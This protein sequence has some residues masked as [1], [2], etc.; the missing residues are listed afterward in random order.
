HPDL[1][2]P[3]GLYLYDFAHFDALHLLIM[4]LIGYAAPDWAAVLNSYYLLG[5]ALTTVTS[6]LFFR[7]LR[8]N[9]AAAVALA[10]LFNFQ[11]Y[12]HIR[13]QGHIMLSAYYLL[14]VQMF[15]AVWLLTPLG[16]RDGE[17]VSLWRSWRLRAACVI[18]FVAVFAGH[19]Y[20]AFALITYAAAAAY[21][22]LRLGTWRPAG[23]AA[24]LWAVAAAGFAV[25]LSP[26]AAY[27]ARE[28]ANREASAKTP[29]QAE[30]YAL[31]LAP[32]LLPV[33]NHRI[34]PLRR[35]TWFYHAATPIPPNGLQ[36]VGLVA[37]AGLVG[38]LAWGVFGGRRDGL[39][40]GLGAVA[41]ALVLFSTTTGFNALFAYAVSPQLHATGRVSILLALLGLT[42]VGLVVTAAV[43]RLGRPAAGAALVAGAGLL[44]LLD[45]WP[46]V[47][48][49]DRKEMATQ[50][51]PAERFAH[52]IQRAVPEGTVIHQMPAR[53]FPFSGYEQ[54]QPYLFTKGLRW[55]CPA[56]LN[57]RGMRWSEEL[58]R[59]P[60]EEMLERLA[61]CG[62]GGIILE[63]EAAHPTTTDMRR[64]L[65]R[66]RVPRVEGET[67]KAFYDLRA[68]AE[69]I[70]GRYGVEE[71]ARRR[72]AASTPLVTLWG[73][74]FRAE[75]RPADGS[76]PFRWSLRQA[77]RIELVNHDDRP[78]RVRFRMGLHMAWPTGKGFT[79]SSPVLG[80]PI[81]L[82]G[83]GSAA[84]EVVLPP[85]RY[86]LT[87]RAEGGAGL[88]L[89]YTYW[90]RIVGFE[91]KVV[92]DETDVARR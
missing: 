39:L 17:G 67:G 12:H 76:G 55:T 66:L 41:V 5:Y 43:E 1:G 49:Y 82:D 9:A 71:L 52:A 83:D 16:L 6:L 14:P 79:V 7:H 50:Y 64:L 57:R 56:M 26:N 11:P 85:G 30:M 54:F 46:A 74:A 86:P 21:T 65:G 32:I 42:A 60:A 40:A 33:K 80:T 70:R 35:L 18:A 38:L 25:N 37:G 73:E 84:A 20:T 47:P 77:G 15:A 19:Y 51:R 23:Q 10:L 31:R 3:F 2:A 75:E 4:K 27:W 34:G 8:M 88:A 61:V 69:A 22:G 28:G 89:F 81:R 13:G 78:I 68:T 29:A 87:V 72:A 58:E 90:F 24:L 63:P 91:A 48:F 92:P 36:P 44:G 53:S 45:V 62:V 59:L